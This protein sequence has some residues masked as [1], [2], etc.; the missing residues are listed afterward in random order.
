MNA[1]R[2][3]VILDG[4]IIHNL[5]LVQRGKEAVALVIKSLCCGG[6]IMLDIKQ[7]KHT[8]GNNENFARLDEF[9]QCDHLQL[10]L[11]IVH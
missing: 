10:K 3:L 8:Y 2:Q 7:L 1:V 6:G 5:I 11:A 4:H 9:I